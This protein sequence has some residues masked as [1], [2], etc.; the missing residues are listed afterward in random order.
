MLSFPHYLLSKQSVDDRALNKD[1]LSALEACWNA[2]RRH[3]GRRRGQPVGAASV[4]IPG[5]G[6]G[7]DRGGQR[8]GLG[9]VSALWSISR[10]C[11]QVACGKLVY[12]AHQMDFFVKI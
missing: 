6:R 5:A 7:A 3:R 11:G 9:G 1:A 4:R 10:R 2:S 12:I 8:I